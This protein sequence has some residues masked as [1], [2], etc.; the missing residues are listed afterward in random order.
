MYLTAETVDLKFYQ[1][2]ILLSVPLRVNSPVLL[3]VAAPVAY[4][5]DKAKDNLRVIS[6]Q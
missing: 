5:E 4:W 1:Y 2:S 6:S 3:R